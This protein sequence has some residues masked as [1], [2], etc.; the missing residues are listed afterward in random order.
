MMDT[1]AARK[2]SM[3][4]A[5]VQTVVLKAGEALSDGRRGGVGVA[6]S[7]AGFLTSCVSLFLFFYSMTALWVGDDPI[8]VNAVFGCN[9]VSYC[10]GRWGIVCF[11]PRGTLSAPKLKRHMI[12][13]AKYVKIQVS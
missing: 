4:T 1:G 6:G 2:R 10:G 13:F 8:G 12:F 11:D 5:S 9:V 7:V 3:S